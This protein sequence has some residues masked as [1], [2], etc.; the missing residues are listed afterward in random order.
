MDV[1]DDQNKNDG[2]DHVNSITDK[3]VD[4]KES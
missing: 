2:E 3:K 1:I 4:N